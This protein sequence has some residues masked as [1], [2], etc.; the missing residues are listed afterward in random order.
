MADFLEISNLLSPWLN[1][2]PYL[3]QLIINQIEDRFTPPSDL[4]TWEDSTTISLC[5][6]FIPFELKFHIWSSYYEL[7]NYGSL[8]DY[9]IPQ[10]INLSGYVPQII[11]LHDWISFDLKLLGDYYNRYPKLKKTSFYL[12]Q[13]IKEVKSTGLERRLNYG[14][15]MIIDKKG[16]YYNTYCQIRGIK[17]RC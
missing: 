16:H 9:N 1:Y 6:N 17:L 4:K 3:N 12:R 11:N 14:L 5:Q 13:L 15:L 8:V 7:C 10:I 2:N